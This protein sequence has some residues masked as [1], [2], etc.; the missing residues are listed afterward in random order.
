MAEVNVAL[1]T[2]IFRLMARRA[3]RQMGVLLLRL[4]PT[5]ANRSLT[6]ARRSLIAGNQSLTVAKGSLIAGNQSLVGHHSSKRTTLLSV[7]R[8]AILKPRTFTRKM[9][10]GSDTIPAATILTII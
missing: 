2:D 6:V 5:V 8:K 7:T 4:L 10:A 3:R 9:T 1:A